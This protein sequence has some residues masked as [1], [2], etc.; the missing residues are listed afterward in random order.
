MDQQNNIKKT[1]SEKFAHWYSFNKQKI[2]MIFIF[3]GTILFTAFLDFNVQNTNFNFQS[4]IYAI[5]QLT[6]STMNNLTAL[7]LFL[8]YLFA[9][10]QLFNGIT[11]NKKNS[12]VVLITMTFITVVQFTLALLYRSAFINE[13]LT[14]SDY[15][16][17][18]ATRLAYS[19]N[20]IGALLFIVGT[21]FAWIYV[22]WKY[23]KEKD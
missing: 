7:F 14:R 3:I 23:V 16:I 21:V 4:H 11:F 9:A 5:Q 20:I 6:S 18:S 17:D 15:T 2:P 22:D 13:A 8:M 1:F 10:I 19:I 12:P